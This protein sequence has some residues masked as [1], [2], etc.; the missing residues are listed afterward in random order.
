MSRVLLRAAMFHSYVAYLSGTLKT[1]APE[2]WL[3]V[4]CIVQLSSAGHLGSAC[5]TSASIGCRHFAGFMRGCWAD[6]GWAGSQR[7][8]GLFAPVVLSEP[9]PE[10]AQ[11]VPASEV[12]FPEVLVGLEC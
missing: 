7:S 10:P 12:R 2:W 8:Y 3:V 9:F 6:L 1:C 4:A 5:P 11:P